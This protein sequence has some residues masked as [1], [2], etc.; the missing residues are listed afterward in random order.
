MKDFILSK[1][2]E[3]LGNKYLKTYSN[4]TKI[5]IDTNQKLLSIE[6]LL[7]GDESPIN[8]DIKYEYNKEKACI[9][10][11]EINASREWMNL[12]AQQFSNDQ[13]LSFDIPGG[14][15]GTTIANILVI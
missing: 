14:K 4:M 9:N 8:I 12:A 11:N 1:F 5:N 13:H 7:K 3:W 15:F 6:V 2:A 10:I